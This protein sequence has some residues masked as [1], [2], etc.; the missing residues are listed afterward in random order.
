MSPLVPL[1][2]STPKLFYYLPQS[3]LPLS[4]TLA[5]TAFLPCGW[6]RFCEKYFSFVLSSTILCWVKLPIDILGWLIFYKVRFSL[7]VQF[8]SQKVP[9]WPNLY[10]WCKKC[11]VNFS[12]YYLAT[13][14]F[15]ASQWFF[16]VFVQLSKVILWTFSP[17]LIKSP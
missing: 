11:T 17:F 8:I 7:L 15:I 12:S 3:L 4:L 6:P 1:L 10:F 14:W 2:L 5:H 16:V 9:I 13:S